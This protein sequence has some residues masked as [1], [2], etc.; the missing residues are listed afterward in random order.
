MSLCPFILL[1]QAAPPSSQ[2][3]PSSSSSPGKSS[4][5]I[6]A[7]QWFSL[8]TLR[9]APLA[10]HIA[11]GVPDQTAIRGIETPPWS[12]RITHFNPISILW[13]YYA[14]AER[15]LRS[16]DNDLEQNFSFASSG[17]NTRRVAVRFNP[18]DYHDD[19]ARNLL[20]LHNLGKWL[21]RRC[22]NIFHTPRNN[23]VAQNSVGCQTKLDICRLVTGKLLLRQRP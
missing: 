13:R 17:F 22:Q 21:L 16:K 20:F 5:S 14:I 10:V 8:F 12:E 7:Y 6:P 4:S 18:R 15:R 23:W 3:L 9:L 1:I 2:L 19:I 11:A